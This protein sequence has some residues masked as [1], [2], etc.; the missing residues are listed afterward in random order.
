MVVWSWREQ[1][2]LDGRVYIYKQRLGLYNPQ[3]CVETLDPQLALA[4]R[5]LISQELTEVT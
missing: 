5:A 1:N 2:R 3:W 4:I